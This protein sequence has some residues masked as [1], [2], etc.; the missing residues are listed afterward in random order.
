[1]PAINRKAPYIARPF[2][3]CG[4]RALGLAWNA[5]CSPERQ[6]WAGDLLSRRAV[7]FVMSEIGGVASTIIL[8]G[9]VDAQRVGKECTV[10]GE[11]TRI[12]SRKGLGLGAGRCFPVPECDGIP[13]DNV[14]RARRRQRQKR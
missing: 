14:F 2:S 7:G 8:A 10:V 12:K 5:A 13:A 3:P 6:H 9:R 11:R 4:Q 1:M